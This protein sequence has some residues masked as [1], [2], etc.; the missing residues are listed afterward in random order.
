MKRVRRAA[1]MGLQVLYPSTG[2]GNAEVINADIVA[3]HG[4]YGDPKSTWTSPQTNAFWLKDFLPQDV[5][6][7]RVMTFGYN[8]DAAFGNTTAEIIDY[9]KSLLSSLI[10]KREQVDELRRPLIF[11]GHSLGGIVIKQ[12]LFQATIEQR[13]NSISESTVGIVFL[14]TPHRGSENVAYGKVLETLAT[15]VRKKPS[16]R[17]INALQVNSE[18]LM[19]LTTDFRLQVPKYQVYSFY[20]MKPMKTLSALVVEKHSALLEILGEEQIPVDASHEEMCKFMA[21]EDDVYEKI[22][23][24]IRRMMG[25]QDCVLLESFSHYNKHYCV[26]HDLSPIF[27]GRDDLIQKI[28]EVFLPS[29]TENRLIKQKRFILYG[30]GGS[31]RLKPASG[32]LMI[33]EKDFGASSGLMRAVK[34]QP[35]RGFWKFLEFVEL[36]RT[37]RLYDNGCQIPRITGY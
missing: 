13:Y 3:V 16:P 17:L 20:E 8:T 23:K 18:A 35:N 25:K 22:F 30:L 9:A 34:I 32:S 5:P 6:N 29:D 15:A 31:G 36:R 1:G 2:A 21:R 33:I 7:A 37:P 26:P 24:R 4:L 27:T 12:S 11:I 19:R 10:D 28:S 14:G